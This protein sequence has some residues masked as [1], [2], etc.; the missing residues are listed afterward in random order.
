MPH[1]NYKL[2]M[3]CYQGI[4]FTVPFFVSNSYSFV[5]IAKFV[6]VI[7]VK[8]HPYR[9]GTIYVVLATCMHCWKYLHV[10]VGLLHEFPWPIPRN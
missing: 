8:G 10:N 3:S 1:F 9:N 4:T 7:E 5:K 6:M 2:I